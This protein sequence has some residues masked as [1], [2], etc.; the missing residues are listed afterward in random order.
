MTLA[1]AGVVRVRASSLRSATE[2][3]LTKLA[4]LLDVQWKAVLDSA[5]AEY[6]GLPSN[7]KQGLLEL[8]NNP[9]NP[10]TQPQPQP[11]QADR[12]RLLYIK[13]RLKQE[14]PTSFA[15]AINPGVVTVGNTTRT[16]LP[17]TVINNVSVTGKTAYVRA[18][19]GKPDNAQTQPIQ[20]SALL[21]LALEQSRGANPT[22][23]IESVIG[24][25]YVKTDPVTGLRYIV[26]SW[27]N[28]LQFFAFP[29]YPFGQGP[30]TTDLDVKL[31][32]P[33]NGSVLDA[34]KTQS[35]DPQD[36]EGLLLDKAF[37]SSVLAN[38]WTPNFNG[39]P[40]NIG[41]PQ[42]APPLHAQINPQVVSTNPKVYLM[43]RLVPVIASAGPDGLLGG[44]VAA[45]NPM[46]AL[47][48]NPDS[49]D[50]LYSF[51]LRQTGGWGD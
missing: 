26:D 5:K 45:I 51:R 32:V 44:N 7:I 28:P 23:A 10:V 36:P 37:Y 38:Q 11:R 31:N 4:S 30:S 3:T 13:F 34:L 39:Q 21:L 42:N 25:T 35:N 2:A 20:S 16:Y 50:N 24:S 1:A 18:V 8:A 47:P 49:F 27:D 15:V 40:L 9:T 29:A 14:F 33:T 48:G 17:A 19:Y 43:R 46:M 22:T 6:D 41:T 12:A